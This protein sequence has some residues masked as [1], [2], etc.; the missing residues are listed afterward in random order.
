MSE[1]TGLPTLVQASASGLGRTRAQ[2]A[3][4]GNGIFTPDFSPSGTQLAA[5]SL[6]AD[7]YHVGVSAATSSATSARVALPEVAPAVAV[8]S[9]TLAPGD[10]HRY[11]AWR[12]ALPRHW[13]PIAEDAPGGGAR[14]GLTTSG[15]DVLYR[16]IY[17]FSAA[18][19]TKGSFPTA[20]LTYRYAG[21]QRPYIDVNLSQDYTRE[22]TLTNGG[23][24]D[25]VGYLLRRRQFAAL[26]ASF[27]RPRVRTFTSLS[28][29][30]GFERRNFRSTPDGFLKQLDPSYAREYRY[31]S[32]FLAGQWANTQRPSLSVSPEDGVSLAFTARERTR[33]DSARA[34]ASSSLIGTASLFKS[35]DLPGYAHHVLALRV[36]GGVA[37]RRAAS[38]FDVGGTSGGTIDI[39]PTYTVGD[40]RR[41]FG[42]RGFPSGSIYGNRAAAA[43]LEY[44]APLKLGGR[45]FGSIPFFFDRSS[46]SAFADAGVATCTAGL[47]NPGVCAP[48]PFIGRT[49][50]SVGGEL[51]LL[52]AIL[53]WDSP[54]RIRLGFAVPVVGR[55]L[56]R[57]RA[58]SGYV[59]YGLSY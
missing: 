6:R 53:D 39:I 29:G 27:V 26:A 16:H 24:T 22:R 43:A 38:A 42:V 4:E 32:V 13:Y 25:I 49:I 37:D 40:G 12:S 47:L 46:V 17:D 34:R 45:G 8:D 18:T 50:A 28:L 36:A 58:V 2:G 21:F 55:D 30:A 52:A 41:T 23:T 1:E 3:T 19:T 57:V 44:R 20:S 9:Q 11:H 54:Q 14:L 7:G 35:L 56:I 48:S 31:P 51:N 15:R 5:V 59:A 10:Y 33:T